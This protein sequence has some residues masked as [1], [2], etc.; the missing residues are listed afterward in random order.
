MLSLALDAAADPVGRSAETS[1]VDAVTA[2]RM[3]LIAA[4]LGE[5]VPTPTGGAGAARARLR[6][7]HGLPAPVSGGGGLGH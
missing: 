1:A 6:A 3:R 4:T 5:T 7:R 2:A